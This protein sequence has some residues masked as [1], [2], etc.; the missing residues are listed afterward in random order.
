ML[1][2]GFLGFFGI[3]VGLYFLLIHL[4]SIRSFGVKYMTPLAPLALSDWKD[5]FVRFPRFLL[6]RIPRAFYE[7]K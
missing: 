2:A 3:M 1:L 5:T 7:K 4:V 6:K